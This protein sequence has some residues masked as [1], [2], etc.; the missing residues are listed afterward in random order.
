MNE[1]GSFLS[2]I[3]E[4][5]VGGTPKELKV[6]QTY[7]TTKPI[8]DVDFVI[9]STESGVE[10]GMEHKRDAEFEPYEHLDVVLTDEAQAREDKRKED[11]EKRMR[12]IPHVKSDPYNSTSG[13]K[14]RDIWQP[15]SLVLAPNTR[16]TV[17]AQEI[18][19][20]YARTLPNVAMRVQSN[21]D[22]VRV[23][24]GGYP[25][26][27]QSVA[28]RDVKTIE[29]MTPEQFM[30]QQLVAVRGSKETLESLNKPP[31]INLFRKS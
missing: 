12:A 20:E 24:P 29:G 22:N 15:P 8:K 18:Q 30:E 23:Y 25:S 28:L 7:V 14:S 3:K 27:T 26:V 10:Y 4:S 21:Y 9:T 17:V 31:K 19:D 16:V 13:Y 2:G 11:W 6:N 5:V 1:D